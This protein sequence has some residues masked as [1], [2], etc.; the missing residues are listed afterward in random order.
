MFSDP[1]TAFI[2]VGLG[3]GGISALVASTAGSDL[4]IPI[5][6]VHGSMEALMATVMI[7]IVKE[8]K[9]PP[10]QTQ[11][12]AH[13]CAVNDS[14]RELLLQ[15]LEDV[16]YGSKESSKEL[17]EHRRDF[18]EFVGDTR[19]RFTGLEDRMTTLEIKTK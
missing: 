14:W 9:A 10:R 11:A 1:L 5:P 19:R 4:P 7:W 18:T 13:D 12:A 2:K 8:I 15:K 6:S 16:A 3:L 17:Q